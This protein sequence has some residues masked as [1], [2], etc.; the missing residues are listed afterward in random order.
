MD[1]LFGGGTTEANL[2]LVQKIQ[3]LLARIICNNFYYIHPRGIDLIR[4]WN[5][6]PYEKDGTIFC[7]F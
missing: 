1:C 6:R 2:N 5:F 3:N 4:H 7:M